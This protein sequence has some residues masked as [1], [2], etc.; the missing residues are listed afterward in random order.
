MRGVTADRSLMCIPSAGSPSVECI[1]PQG[2]WSNGACAPLCTIVDLSEV[3][4][5][6]T[7]VFTELPKVVNLFEAKSGTYLMRAAGQQA[8]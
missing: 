8:R 2:D 3:G 7:T 4:A 5:A 1:A 6:P